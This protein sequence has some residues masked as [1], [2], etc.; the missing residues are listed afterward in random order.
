[1][2][3]APDGSDVRSALP[4]SLQ[5]AY[6]SSRPIATFDTGGTTV[7]I[8]QVLSGTPAEVTA[9]IKTEH[10]ELVAGG[11]E[12]IASKR[13]TLSSVSDKQLM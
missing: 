2:A 11:Q 6:D 4:S 9:G 1:M 8:R 12:I 10:D 3:G 5:G 7:E 13:I